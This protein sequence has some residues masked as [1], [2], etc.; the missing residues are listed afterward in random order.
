MFLFSDEVDIHREYV[1][2]ADQGEAHRQYFTKTAVSA[3]LFK[4]IVY[5]K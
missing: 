1:M 2:E 3:F 4:C 5:R